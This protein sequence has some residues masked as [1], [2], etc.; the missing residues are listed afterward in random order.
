MIKVGDWVRGKTENDELFK[1]FIETFDVIH[2]VVKVFIVESDHS[3]LISKRIVTLR[4]HVTPL[5]VTDVKHEEFIRDMI[6]LALLTN[7]RA[8][9]DDLVKQLPLKKQDSVKGTTFSHINRLNS[10]R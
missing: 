10:F 2:G 6:D 8:W 7:D 1:G 4:K 3:K 5:A 9:F